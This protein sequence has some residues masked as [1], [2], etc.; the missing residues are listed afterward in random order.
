MLGKYVF[1]PDLLK[2]EC[3]VYQRL[4]LTAWLTALATAYAA[5]FMFIFSLRTRTII[6]ITMEIV[7]WKVHVCSSPV[8]EAM[9]FCYRT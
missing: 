6:V 4:D 8:S 9:K 1:Q 5:F 2:L 3:A 7:S